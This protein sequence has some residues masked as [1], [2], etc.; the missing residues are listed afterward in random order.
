M[1]GHSKNLTAEE[2][3]DVIEIAK[4]KELVTIQ[5][6]AYLAG[7]HHSTIRNYVNK[8]LIPAVKVGR[9]YKL[10]REEAMEILASGKL[11][12]IPAK[13]VKEVKKEPSANNENVNG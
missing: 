9:N 13:E 1:R 12:D 6:L 8:G 10:N 5:E 3:Q 2:I 11:A 7:F 4:T